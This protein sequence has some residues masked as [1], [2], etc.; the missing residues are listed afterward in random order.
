M[1]EKERG[2]TIVFNGEI[3]NY[4]EIRKRL[5][6]KGSKFFSN[7]DTEV[8]LR[9]GD[10]LNTEWLSQ[11]N[12]MFAFALWDQHAHRLLLAR[13]R[14]GIKPLYYTIFKD[15]FLFASE[16]KALLLFPDLPRHINAE[17][18]PEY[19][20]F[21][22]IVGPETMF[23]NIY[24]VPA[25]HVLR[26]SPEL[27][28]PKLEPYQDELTPVDLR[29]VLSDSPSEEQQLKALLTD[30]VKYRLISDVPVGTFSSGGVDSSL[31][32]AAARA[33][34]N[35]DLHTFSVGFQD[36]RY[37]ESMYAQTVADELRTRHHTIAMNSYEFAD[38]LQQMI[39]YNDE[40][41]NHPHTVQLLKLSGIAKKICNGRVNRGRSR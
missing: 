33:Q 1:V 35:G 34:T 16:I 38:D 14:L 8:L 30:A 7:S 28:H 21:R 22:S 18:I 6:A 37:D 41:L 23:S 19:L 26:I 5:Q 24:E 40:P 15:F 10:T 9:L 31:V 29:D 32:T 3:Y 11:L 2:Q 13:D 12:G 4:Q 36:K 25:G 39:W 17:A 27:R 20:A